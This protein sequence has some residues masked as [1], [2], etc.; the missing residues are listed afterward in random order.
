M[1]GS[2]AT[3][4]Y[5]ATS[6]TRSA[7]FNIEFVEPT[8]ALTKT[9]SNTGPVDADDS[10]VVTLSLTNPTASSKAPAYVI[11]ISD[12]VPSTVTLQGNPTITAG[13]GTVSVSNG[14]ISISTATFTLGSTLTVTYTVKVATNIQTGTSFVLPG[15]TGTYYSNKITTAAKSYTITGANVTIPVL[16]PS[17]TFSVL[18][19]SNPSTGS[20]FFNRKLHRLILNVQF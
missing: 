4:V 19:T 5:L 2:I 18:S 11:S 13:T 9:T 14:V 3:I 16:A 20:Q 12:T 1:K 17:F 8:L 10:I 15:A 6:A 7:T